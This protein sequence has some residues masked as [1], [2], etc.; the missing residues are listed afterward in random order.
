MCLISLSPVWSMPPNLRSSTSRA[1][2]LKALTVLTCDTRLWSLATSLLRFCF[3]RLVKVASRFST[4]ASF[5]RYSSCPVSLFWDSGSLISLPQGKRRII[6]SSLLRTTTNFDQCIAKA[7]AAQDNK[8]GLQCLFAFPIM[9][10]TLD[11]QHTALT[12]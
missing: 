6:F 3:G 10:Q 1:L 11:L 9:N 5:L 2:F 8:H 7:S 4:F 12:G